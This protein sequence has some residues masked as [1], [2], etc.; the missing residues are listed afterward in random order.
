VTL[1]A[2]PPKVLPETVTGNTPHVLPVVLPRVRV[3]GFMHPQ[4]TTKIVPTVVHP[5]RF[6]TEIKWLAL[7][8]ELKIASV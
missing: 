3:G 4:E 8:T 2:V 5:A 7:D 6:L 1:V